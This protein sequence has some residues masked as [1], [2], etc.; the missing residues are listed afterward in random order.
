M[1]SWKYSSL[2]S[3][4]GS[5]I[6][7]SHRMDIYGEP[8]GVGD[9]IGCFINLSESIDINNKISF[10]KV[11]YQLRLTVILSMLLEWS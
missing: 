5:K 4:K 10:F 2:L 1:L 6:H 3:I 8:Y 9:V 7:N 11:H